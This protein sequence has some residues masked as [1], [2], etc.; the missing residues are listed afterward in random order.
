MRSEKNFVNGKSH[1]FFKTYYENG[2]KKREDIYK[3]DKLK[4]GTIWN[5][6]G[7]EVSW[8]PTEERPEFPGGQKAL[9][10]YLQENAKKPKEVQSGRVLVG[11][12]IDVDGT[13]VDITI[14]ETTSIGLNFPAYELV[15]K[16]PKWSPGKQDGKPVRVKYSLPLNFR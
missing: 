15:A 16:M 13:V 6:D 2:Q 3:K 9:L 12:V 1:G 10:K 8:Y 11:F 14:K 5:E 7:N 4:E